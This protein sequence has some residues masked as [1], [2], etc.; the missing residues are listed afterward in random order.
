MPRF[1]CESCEA[2]LYSAASRTGLI[3]PSCPKCGVSLQQQGDPDGPTP[4]A[5]A[6]VEA[7]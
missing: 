4:M 3:E 1:I 2:S 5:V 7:A 6:A